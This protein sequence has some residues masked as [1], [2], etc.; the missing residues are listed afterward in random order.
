MFE[1]WKVLKSKFDGMIWLDNLIK[2]IYSKGIQMVFLIDFIMILKINRSWLCI[3]KSIIFFI[4][5]CNGKGVDAYLVLYTFQSRYIICWLSIPHGQ[6]NVSGN[7]HL[8][9]TEW[10]GNITLIYGIV[11]LH[12]YIYD[13]WIRIRWACHNWFDSIYV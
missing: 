1:L 3:Y 10:L 6:A 5:L 11:L 4:T 9:T 12:M 13:N 2:T 8:I 7:A